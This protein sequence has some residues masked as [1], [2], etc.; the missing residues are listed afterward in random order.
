[1]FMMEKLPFGYIS[2]WKCR[3]LELPYKGKELSMIILLPDEIEDD[4][5]GLEQVIPLVLSIM[6][7]Y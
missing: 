3:V 5:T 7:Q 2:E 1:M 4:S 6:F